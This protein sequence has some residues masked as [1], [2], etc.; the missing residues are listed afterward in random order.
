MYIYIHYHIYIYNIIIIYCILLLVDSGVACPYMPNVYIEYIACLIMPS[1]SAK[2]EPGAA[3]GTPGPETE[4][5]LMTS[6]A[7]WEVAE[8]GEP[9]VTVLLGK[10]KRTSSTN[11]T[12]QFLFPKRMPQSNIDGLV[13]GKP[14]I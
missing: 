8:K 11:G 1:P 3:L 14:S 12:N 10:S 4:E 5:E 13:K 6:M 9:R 2:D 7:L